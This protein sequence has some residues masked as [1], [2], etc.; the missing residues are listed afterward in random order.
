MMLNYEVEPAVLPRLLPAGVE[1]DLWQGR[2]LVSMVGFLF[3]KTRVLGVSIPFHRDFEEVNL[4]FYVRRKVGSEWRRGVTFVREIVPRAAIAITARLTYNEPYLALPMRHTVTEERLEFG[5][6]FA[7]RWNSM[8][9]EVR[10]TPTPLA[11]GSEEEFIL[12][13]YWGYTAQRDGGTVEYEV[14]HPRWQA[15]RVVSSTLDCEVAD[16]YGESFVTGLAGSP[17][18]AFMAEG[19]PVRVLQARRLRD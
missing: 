7:R 18:S 3:R 2:T 11:P 6:K 13:H 5:W 10:G 17:C 16:I 19:S 4:R 14:E 1:L 8:T 9:A 12:E 15:R